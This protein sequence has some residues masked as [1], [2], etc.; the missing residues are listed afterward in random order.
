MSLD[1]VGGFI[2]MFYRYYLRFL[3]ILEDS[4]RFLRNPWRFLKIFGD[5]WGRLVDIV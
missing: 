1:D 2:T 3:E 5:L 4:W